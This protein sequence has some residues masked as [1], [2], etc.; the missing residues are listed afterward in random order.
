MARVASVTTPPSVPTTPSAHRIWRSFAAKFVILLTIFL[1]VPLVTYSQFR[2]ADADKMALVL[3]GVEDQGRLMAESLA[4]L[5]DRFDPRSTVNLSQALARL[6]NDTTKAKLLYRPAGATDLKN[7]F[8][9]AATPMVPP[10]YLEREQAELGLAGVIDQLPAICQGGQPVPLRFT[11]PAGEEEVLTSLTPVIAASGCWVLITS[12][13]TR[14]YLGT[15]IGQ[16]YWMTP[17][18]QATGAIYVLVVLVVAWMFFDAWRSLNRFERLARNIRTA[19]TAF[20]SFSQLNRIPELDGV[21]EE[22]DRLVQ[23]LQSSAERIR[24]TAEENAHAFKTPLGVISQSV[25]PLKRAVPPDNA[26]G[27]RAIEVIE[28]AVHRLDKLVSAARQTD[29]ATAELVDPPRQRIDLSRLLGELT[30]AYR[31]APR[32][33][34]VMVRST[35]EPGI[36]VAGGA[37]LLETVVENLVDNALSFSPPNGKV[38]VILRRN[39]GRAEL[40][41][42]DEGPGVDQALAERIFDRYFSQR[43]AEPDDADAKAHERP[44]HFGIGL[45]IVRRNVEA[46]GGNVVAENRA[47]GG[48]RMR[49]TLPLAR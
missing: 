30:N 13:G 19:G 49:V 40:L 28:E 3:K 34:G 6:A 43:P 25:E 9:V 41:V 32:A 35:I 46:I 22:F 18:M 45:W 5:L 14:D 44:S 15:S 29:E 27:H 26:R 7:F 23:S 42:E 1:A 11:N 4:P 33:D 31:E 36:F 12:H 47:T 24:R 48:L 2:A 38:A 39:A 8:Y 17:E 21:A 20:A 37:D 16:P 10:E